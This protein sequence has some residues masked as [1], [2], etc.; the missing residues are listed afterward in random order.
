MALENLTTIVIVVIEQLLGREGFTNAQ[1]DGNYF[2][3]RCSVDLLFYQ[4]LN[5]IHNLYTYH[6]Q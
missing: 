3:S 4:L 1:K 2:G 5:I 6:L